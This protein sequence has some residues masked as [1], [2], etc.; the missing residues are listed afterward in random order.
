MQAL[1]EYRAGDPD[2][3]V[4][5]VRTPEEF[6]QGHVPGALPLELSN[7]TANNLEQLGLEKDQK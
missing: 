5:D 2:L 7:L 4:L 6:S 1:K 3:K